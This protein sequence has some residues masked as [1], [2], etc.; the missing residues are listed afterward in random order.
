MGIP[1]YFNYV[2]NNHNEIFQSREEVGTIDE[3]YLDGNSII[4]DV[5]YNSK[6]QDYMRIYQLVCEKIDE[7]IKYIC[8]KQL[9]YISFDGIPPLAKVTQQKERRYK[10]IL[11]KELTNKTSEFD[12]CC[13]TPGTKFMT[14][15]DNFLVSYFKNYSIPMYI[16]GSKEIGEGEHKLFSFIKKKDR[17]HTISIYG[18]DAD[19]IILSLQNIYSRKNIYLC[20]ENPNYNNVLDEKFS[21]EELCF[22]DI[23]QLSK[24]ISETLSPKDPKKG[25]INDY[26][27]MSY[28]LGNDFMPHFPSINIR[29]TGIQLL[30]DTYKKMKGRD[31]HFTFSRV[32]HI[33][34]RNVR[35]FLEEIRGMEEKLLIEET[36]V[37]QRKHT[38]TPFTVEERIN[39]IP[40]QHR[41]YERYINPSMKNWEKRYYETLFHTSKKEDIKKICISYMEGLEWTHTYYTQGCKEYRWFYPYAY[42]PLLTDLCSSIPHF[43]CELLERKYNPIHPYTLLSYVLPISSYSLLPMHVRDIMKSYKKTDSSIHFVWAYCRYFWECHVESDDLTISQ[44]EEILSSHSLIQEK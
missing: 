11:I 1:S 34:W 8:P 12:T 44:I 42:A 22:L 40:S 4:Y 16:S 13:I 3:F 14:G 10:S 39:F 15:L 36:K 18:L 24:N 33:Q 43:E 31:K 35:M 27:F 29:R 7:Y 26:V 2:S 21:K 20:R 38:H 28:F 37:L 23:K 5:I 25:V 30:M 9:V 41:D 17:N 32:N 6:E 19:L